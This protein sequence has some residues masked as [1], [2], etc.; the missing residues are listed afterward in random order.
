MET[1]ALIDK[2]KNYDGKKPSKLKPNQPL[3]AYSGKTPAELKK[4]LRTM[5]TARRVEREEKLLLRKGYNRFFIGCGGKE[6]MDVALAEF[7]TASDPFSGYYRNKAFDLHRGTTLWDKMLE[8]IGDPRSRNKGQQI[9]AHPGYSDLGIIPQSSPTG[10]HAL[11]HAGISEAVKHPSPVSQLSQFPGGAYPKDAV[12]ILCIGEGSTSETE[13][14]RAVFYTTFYKTRAIFAIY[15]CGWAISVNV[16]EQYPDGDPTASHA[17]LTKYGL[18]IMHFDGTDIKEALAN[19]KEAFDYTR[20]GKGPV[21]MNVKTTREGSHSGSDD[22]SF[23]M[24]PVEL[25]W[26]TYND[27]ILKT[28]N[29]FIEDGVIAPQEVG[30]MWDELD[31]EISALSAKAVASFQPKT[32]QFIQDLV[33]TYNFEDIKKTWKAYRDLSKVNREANYKRYHEKGYFT[34]PE[35]PE[36]AGPMTMRFAIN[37]TLFDLFQLTEDILLFGEDVADFSGHMVEEKEKQTKLKGKGGVF[38][39]T[40]NLQRE[41]GN[42]RCFNSPLDEAGILGRASGHVYQ[43]RRPMPEIQF[44]DYMSPAYQILKDRI[45]TTY[46]RSGGE[47]KMPMT[48]R[49]TFGGYKQGAGAFWHSE[50]NMGTWMNFPGMHIVTPSNAYDAAGLLKTAWACDDLVLFCESVALYNRRDWDGIPIETELPGIDEL[51]PFGVARV[52]NPENTDVGIITY[53]A[54]VQMSR[55]AAEILKDRG[56]NIR[57]VDLRTLKPIDEKEIINT[58]KECGKV[59]IVTEDRFPGGCGATI[60]SIITQGE[61]L[62]HLEAPVK[63][64][65]A[66]DA[67][68]AYG[69]DGDEACLPTVDKIVAAVEDL[70]NNY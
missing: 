24:D 32:T 68:V 44:L 60:S 14:N 18:K 27:C 66:I 56:I 41:F 51:I 48:I 61:G 12:S 7:S 19:V 6:L 8:A 22:Q 46:Q 50:S 29:A 30:E 69:M 5:L 16:H 15:N 3:E 1:L 35:I 49:C 10:A 38:L 70:F 23:Y 54:T 53:S 58:A 43:G 17:G 63:L 62:F 2:I 28:C 67:R 31:I 47:F 25:D 39:V 64:L 11:E 40:K 9:P 33:Y 37:Y 34:T 36:K 42:H 20:E 59:L 4:M 21:L 52:Y 13:F 57:I 45:A 65:T 26:H 55:K